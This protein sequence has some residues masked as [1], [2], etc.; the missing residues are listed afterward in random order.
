MI[1]WPV[2]VSNMQKVGLDLQKYY[3]VEVLTLFAGIKRQEQEETQIGMAGKGNFR[4]KKTCLK[5][6]A[7]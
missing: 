4:H 5:Q 2:K 3:A 6:V 7:W 1:P